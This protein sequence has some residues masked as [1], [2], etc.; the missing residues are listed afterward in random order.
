M[1]DAS[2]QAIVGDGAFMMTCMEILTAAH[3]ELGV[4]YFVFN[5]GELSQIAQAQAIPYNRKT[6]TTLGK[7]NLEGVALATGAAYLSMKDNAAIAGVIGK[8]A[9]SPGRAAG[10]RR[11][12]H[13]L[14]EADGLH[15]RGREDQFRPFP[16]Q[17]KTALPDPRRG[18]PRR[19]LATPRVQ[20]SATP[21]KPRAG[22][23]RVRPPSWLTTPAIGRDA[24]VGQPQALGRR[25]GLPEHVDRD[26]AARIPIAADAQPAGRDL[27]YEPPADPTVQ[28]S[29]KR[30]GCGRSARYSFSDLIRRSQSPG[31]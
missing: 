25:A 31:T 26:A 9:R 21:W 22:E 5:D 20:R 27:A 18:P 30:R 28:S 10:H 17:R 2:V 3:N 14:L 8:A 4:V 19:R 12:A 29:W 11:R 15:D 7:L 1:P 13:R 23:G 16:P 24:L 6:C